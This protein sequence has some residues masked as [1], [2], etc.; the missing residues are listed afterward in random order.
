MNTH[1]SIYLVRAGTTK[2]AKKG[3][4]GKWTDHASF[5]ERGL[6]LLAVLIAFS[7]VALRE[8]QT[9][10]SFQHRVASAMHVAE[11]NAD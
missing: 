8:Q 10:Q 1:G 4:L 5:F 9:L 6:L 3:R 2:K 11:L 7:A